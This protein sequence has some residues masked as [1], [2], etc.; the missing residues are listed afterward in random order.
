M[1]IPF[2]VC[3]IRSELVLTHIP[4]PVK[5]QVRQ[6]AGFGCSKCGLPIVQYHH[7][8][9]NS[10]DPK[11]I[12]LLCPNHHTEAT[13]GAMLKKEQIKLKNNPFNI[14]NGFVKGKLKVNQETPV[15]RL[16]K[17]TFVGS[18]ELLSVDEENLISLIIKDDQLLVSLKLYDEN[19]N[20]LVEITENQWVS[21]DP[22]PWDIEAKHQLLKIRRKR[23]DISLEIDAKK[24]PIEIRANMWRKKQNFQI[25]PKGLLLDGAVIKQSAI[26][27]GCFIGMYFHADTKL[28]QFT[29][30][31]YSRFGK[32]KIIS[33]Q[34]SKTLV[35]KA[36]EAWSLISCE[37]IFER[38]IDRKKYFVLKCKKCKQIQKKW[39]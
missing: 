24:T 10:E 13:V 11:D 16:G 28:N 2:L 25:G 19:D 21:G 33:G 34:F 8:V 30:R 37:H 3:L 27:G 4:E 18:G 15:I 12:M 26:I 14:I 32:G 9:R 23:G 39:K 29:I 7:I 36:L 22:I 20:L 38:I 6:D 1:H 5:R 17:T 35:K 31:P